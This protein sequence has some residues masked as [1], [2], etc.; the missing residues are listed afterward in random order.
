MELRQ[1]ATFKHLAQTLSF[2]GTA[3]ALSYAQST[4]SAQIRNLEEE[5][6]VSLFERLG[7]RVALTAEGQKF[8]T[9]VDQL[10]SLEAEAKLAFQPQNTVSGRLNLYAPSTLCVQRL[11]QILQ[12]FREQYP[13]V[14]INI[15][16]LH[17]DHV[18][19]AV[20]S[21]K[22]DF[23]FR[24]APPIQISDMVVEHLVTEPLGFYVHPSHR[25]ANAVP[26]QL[27]DLRTESLILSEPGCYYRVALEKDAEIQGVQFGDVMAFENTEAMKQCAITGLGIAFMPEVVAASALAAGT[28]V[29]LDV[30]AVPQ[31]MHTQLIYHKDKWLSPTM[32]AF[33][34]VV[35]ATSFGTELALPEKTLNQTLTN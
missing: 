21:G 1:L 11:P 30:Q 26:F 24:L 10:L 3:Q 18:Y 34:A 20:R 8:L 32:L 29:K 4:V 28:L 14:Q 15:N 5:L 9:Y 17:P 19:E 35:R 25:L 33:L 7:K 27:K 6:A 13:D 2:S 16:T 31:E 12:R 23:A 22:F